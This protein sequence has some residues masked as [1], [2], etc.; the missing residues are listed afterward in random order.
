MQTIATSLQHKMDPHN[1]G[2][3]GTTC[4]W[5]FAARVVA[6]S[7]LVSMATGCSERTGMVSGIVTLE[8]KPLPVG[9]VLFHPNER[10]IA[11]ASGRIDTE[12]HYSLTR[13][14]GK[15]GAVVGKYH[16]TVQTVSSN[17]ADAI[18]AARKYVIPAVY[19][20]PATTPLVVEVLPGENT[21][22]LNVQPEPRH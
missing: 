1:D 14:K 3:V 20:D 17:D 21:I 13:A 11:P 12:G 10:G 4:R 9:L 5:R 22:D 6:S 16:V 2:I 8:G 19:D 7:L 18:A 15:Q